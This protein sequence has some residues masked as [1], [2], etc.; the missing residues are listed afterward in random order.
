[1]KTRLRNKHRHCGYAKITTPELVL[2]RLRGGKNLTRQGFFM[3]NIGWRGREVGCIGVEW[4]GCVGN[5]A[6]AGQIPRKCVDRHPLKAISSANPVC[7]AR[8]WV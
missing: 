1:M 6:L 5:P 2:V 3:V 7:L 8:Q 4:T